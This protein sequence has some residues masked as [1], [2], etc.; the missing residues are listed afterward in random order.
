MAIL[1]VAEHDNASLS[2]QTAKALTA[3][4]EDR[5]ATST[6]WSPARAPRPPP[7]PPPS[8][9]GVAKVLLA[10]GDELAN[11]L[12]EPLAALI[13]VARRRL[14]HDR[15]AG[16]HVGQERHAAR[17]RPAR[18]RCRSPRSSRSSRPTRSSGRSMP[19]TPSRRCSRPTPR[20]S[21]PCAP[22]PSRRAGEGGSAP[23]E[24]VAAAA[25]P[26][27]STFVE[28]RLSD[29]DRPE[30][31][32]AKIII[33]GG[34]ALGSAEKFQE[35][36]LPVADKLGAAVG[37]S[38]RRGRCRLCAERLAGRPD[39]QGRRARPLHR[40]RHLRRHPAPRRH[41]GLQGHRRHQQGRGSADLPGRRLRPRRRPL[42]RSCRSS[43]RRFDSRAERGAQ[44]RDGRGRRSL[45]R[46]SS[47]ALHKEWAAKP[48]DGISANGRQDRDG[49]H[50][51]RRPDGQRHRPCLR[52]SP[53][54]RSCSTTSR[55]SASRRAS[56]R[57][58]A[59]WPARSARA[60]STR[61]S[62]RR[63]WRGSRPR[64][65]MADLAGCRSRH[66][67]GDRGRDGQAQDLRAALPAARSRKRSSPP[68]PRRSRS[69]GSPPRPTGR[70]ASSASI[71]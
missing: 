34:R 61:P 4:A 57:S 55:P 31:T 25:N 43:K 13:V 7:T 71:S 20:R 16:H 10:E 69:P 38:P 56:P 66:R 12:A 15:R 18:R 30:L 28:N 68:T 44:N 2:D 48:C 54:T 8:S 53:A 52:R 45:P 24:T 67:G 51:R 39:R 64:L 70:S 17:R 35:V 37:A 62:G 42:R 46:P 36:I 23:V 63:R 6:C 27:L 40:R 33:S 21:S 22:P 1:L 9:T 47:V 41:E 32:S 50:R 60:S 59:T 11:R 58:A 3:A 49:R 14:R 65:P 19:A 29:S 26:G 5:R